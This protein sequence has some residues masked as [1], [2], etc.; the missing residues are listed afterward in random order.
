VKGLA[1]KPAHSGINALDG[2]EHSVVCC[3]VR[4]PPWIWA[5]ATI[6]LVHK[7]AA[8]RKRILRSI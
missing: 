1:N 8:I 4:G 7:S 2:L 5:F 6:E 3:G